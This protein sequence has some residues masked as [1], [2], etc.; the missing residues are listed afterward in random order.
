M[1]HIKMV[2]HIGEARATGS[3]IVPTA[4]DSINAMRP[5]SHSASYLNLKAPKSAWATSHR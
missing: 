5:L 2:A 3:Q 4:S 1:I